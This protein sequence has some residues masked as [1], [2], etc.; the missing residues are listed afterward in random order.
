VIRALL[1]I[2]FAA[3]AP[4][5]DERT[6]AI[7]GGTI[8]LGDPAV[9]AVTTRARPCG[10]AA[11]ATCS[12]TLIG[13]RAVLTAAHCVTEE[14]PS[15]LIV[16]GGAR[17][18]GGARVEIEQVEIHPDYDGVA[19]DLAVI[20]LATPLADIPLP[21]GVLDA[22][23][24]GA[25]VRVVGFG[26]DEDEMTGE[27]RQGTSR[28]A[29]LAATTFVLAP[30]PALPCHADS[31]GPV[32]IADEIVGVVAYGDPA[33]TTSTTVTRVDVHAAF[34]TAALA[35]IAAHSP[36]S[37]P[38]STE[39]CLSCAVST[40][41]PRGSDCIDGTCALL[42]AERAML[43][44]TCENDSACGGEPC[45]AGLDEACRCLASCETTDGCGCATGGSPHLLPLLFVAV[46]L[47]RRRVTGA[48]SKARA[49][50]RRSRRA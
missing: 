49:S 10:M 22:A 11:G 4:D 40:D 3:C 21:T 18:D 1:L 47:V 16:V 27:K 6:A 25:T 36:V 28:I 14:P 26:A 43:G 45:L 37:R 17:V 35:R 8:D 42:G 39:A 13:P 31:G 50:R 46:L 38:T 41:C 30:D 23:D 5:V 33:C 2:A 19:A 48:G 24:L 15:A 9:V 29:E 44:S 32:F 7:V 12:G 20:E 34:V